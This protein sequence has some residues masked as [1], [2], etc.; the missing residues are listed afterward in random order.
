VQTGLGFASTLLLLE[1]TCGCGGG[2]GSSVY[3]SP[4]GLWSIGAQS[5]SSQAL[6]VGG[7]LNVNGTDVSGIMHVTSPSCFSEDIDIPVTGTLT[8][9][10]NLN[11]LFPNGQGGVSFSLTNPGG[12][13]SFV[14][15]SY[16]VTASGCIPASQGLASGESVTVG[17]EWS[18]NLTS[19]SST[20]TQIDMLLTQTGPDAH[21][22]FS[23]TGTATLT[24]A[25][26]FSAAT[27]DAANTR[28][29]GA[30]STV[31]LVST[32]PTGGTVVLTGGF[33]NA[34]TFAAFIGKYT[35]NL[36]TC[37]QTG[38]ASMSTQS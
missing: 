8:N 5:S 12:Q 27:V 1:L 10:I 22:Y 31:T 21:G 15:G 14:I 38:T 16:S 26:C 7:A 6:S 13:E 29:L 35:S 3:L 33:S 19:P 25:T 18:G 11:L 20:T 28:I 37:S 2:G 17:G 30:G 23:A 4:P 9:T 24:G 36:G 32:S 34:E